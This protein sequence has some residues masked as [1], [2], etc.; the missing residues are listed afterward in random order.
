MR[1]GIAIEKIGR[2]K[3][4]SAAENKVLIH[5][6]N[7][8]YGFEGIKDFI[9]LQEDENKVIWALQAADKDYPSLIVVDPFMVASGYSPALTSAQKSSLGN[10]EPEDLCYLSV[11]VIRRRLEDSVINL[12]SPIVINAKSHTGMQVIL[13]GSD[14]PVEYRP[15]HKQKCGGQETCS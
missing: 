14:Y 11:M 4:E 6:P 5:F 3:M 13:D 10:P 9:L 12:K 7:G 15:F 1:E 8:I 2:L